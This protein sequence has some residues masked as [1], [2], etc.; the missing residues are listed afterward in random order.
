MAWDDGLSPE[1]RQ[2]A[3]HW[4]SSA[5]VLAGP[6]TGKTRSLIQ[7][8]AYL[9]QERE[10]PPDQIVVL[11]FTRAAARELRERL[12]QHLGVLEDDLP[13]VCTL[14]SFALRTLL[15]YQAQSAIIQPLRVADDY[16]EKHVLFH[17]IGQMI[18]KPASE[19]GKAL[20]GF[21]ATWNTLNQEH[22]AWQAVDFRREFEMA[23][24]SLSKFYGF[25]LRG[26]LVFR[27]LRL[28]NGNPLIGQNLGV[29]H[30]LV[31]E[32]Q[33][34]N[35]CDQQVIARLEEFGAY[36][37]VVGDDDQSIY[38]FRHAYPDG[39]RQFTN[40]RPGCGDYR[41]TTCHRC[42]TA[43][44]N[45]A[46][47]LIGWDRT[48]V[49]RDLQPES[50]AIP[51]EVYAL[52]FQGYADEADGIANICK[53]YVDADLLRPQDISIL[54]SRRSLAKRIAEGLEKAGLPAVV[55][56]PI[57]P[58]G[59]RDDPP[60]HEGRLIYCVLRLLVD[61]YDALAARTWMGLQ[62]GVGL[63][64]IKHIREFCR[65]NDR[66]LWDGLSSIS[67]DPTLI[68][69]GRIVKAHFDELS[70]ILDELRSAETVE[71][72]LD[73]LVGPAKDNPGAE[74]AQVR[75]FL[76]Y[77]IEKE[78][79][80]SVDG[81]VQTLQTFDVEAETQLT[82]NAVRVM[83]MHKAKGLSSEMVIIPALEQDLM[84]GRF[85]EDLARRMMYVAMTRS[86]RVLIF[87]HSL[88]RTGAQSYLGTGRG[89]WQRQ[90]SRFL[91]EMEIRSRDGRGFISNLRQR[92]LSVPDLPGQV[93][94]QVLRNLIKE[95]LSD[96]E[97]GIFC[98]DHFR[99]VYH[100]FGT[101][102]SK[103]VK[104]QRLIEYCNSHHQVDILLQ[105]LR[106]ANE[107]QFARFERY[108]FSE[109]SP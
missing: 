106:E 13:L 109:V 90:R 69:R 15:Q 20:R 49:S 42:P 102:M 94:T 38:H 43:I 72:V 37:Y 81:L 39:I 23:L 1:Q 108:L 35:H 88:T 32:Y 45:L 56:V 21:E 91:D 44:V 73:H 63:G 51:G 67:A 31:D 93:N 76:D 25:T 78:Q 11:T 41:L 103:T 52:Q 75:Q 83:T 7:R 82:A 9:L 68:P 71:N 50:S 26:E 24:R 27:L 86:R 10:V 92:L 8:V 100:Q 79:V 58:L 59:G 74:K 89:Q 28:L 4:G 98:Y 105:K 80:E 14:H 66:T 46:T 29:R 107:A 48:R 40:S 99:E 64:T 18:G 70:E 16:E 97:L 22:E 47:N 3:S 19:V 60:K 5:R 77:V 12:T 87:T 36:L 57:W 34:L 84:P 17:E 6:G 61:Q 53:T 101:G 55:L 95:S 62:N 104:I 96:E 33:D 54:L 85:S 30:V 2:A 65:S